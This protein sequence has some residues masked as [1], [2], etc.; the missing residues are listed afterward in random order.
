M[1]YF[2][3]QN[4]FP[5][6]G[7]PVLESIEQDNSFDVSMNSS[8]EATPGFY[9]MAE[10]AELIKAEE[11]SAIYSS[12]QAPKPRAKRLH[13]CTLCPYKS[14][15]FYNLKRHMLSVH[16]TIACETPRSYACSVRSCEFNTFKEFEFRDHVLTC[17][18]EICHRCKLCEE[19]FIEKKL[20]ELHKRTVHSHNN[21]NGEFN[22]DNKLSD[23][24][25]SVEPTVKTEIEDDESFEIATP[26]EDDDAGNVSEKSPPSDVLATGIEPNSRSD[27]LQ[28]VEIDEHQ[29]MFKV[30][31]RLDSSTVINVPDHDNSPSPSKYSDEESSSSSPYKVV[32]RDP[33]D[34]LCDVDEGNTSPL[35]LPT[36]VEDYSP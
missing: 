9:S 35:L 12:G 22:S 25:E 5:Y 20:L 27:L 4:P 1:L 17:H 7:G 30:V 19:H 2:T 32:E 3:F 21:K 11:T 31:D 23:G 6:E 14:A 29:S 13:G 34:S 18:P 24:M 33:E 10:T 26:M 15:R 28:D 36:I 16:A 8:M